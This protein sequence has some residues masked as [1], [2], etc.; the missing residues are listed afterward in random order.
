MEVTLFLLS[1]VRVT[2]FDC[3]FLKL[4]KQ[5]DSKD[6]LVSLSNKYSSNTSSWD[7]LFIRVDLRKFSRTLFFSLVVQHLLTSIFFLKSWSR[8]DVVLVFKLDPRFTT[9][10]DNDTRLI[11][12]YIVFLIANITDETSPVELNSFDIHSSSP[13]YVL[14][15]LFPTGISVFVDFATEKESESVS[16]RISLL[17]STHCHTDNTKTLFTDET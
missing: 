2:E 15:H 14:S 3:M 4:G 8:N 12:V 10:L 13:D 11:G 1:T 5:G 7:Y 16:T 17:L 6:H 9:I